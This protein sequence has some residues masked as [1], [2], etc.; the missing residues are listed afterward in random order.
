MT[1]D[2]SPASQSSIYNFSGIAAAPSQVC[3]HCLKVPRLHPADSTLN[4][5]GKHLCSFGSHAKR[6]R[7]DSNPC[8]QSPMDFESI[9]LTARTHCH[10]FTAN[11]SLPAHC[12]NDDICIIQLRIAGMMSHICTIPLR[13]ALKGSPKDTK[14][15][16][17]IYTRAS[18]PEH[19]KESTWH[20][21]FSND[22]KLTMSGSSCDLQCVA[23]KPVPSS[24]SACALR[25]QRQPQCLPPGLEHADRIAKS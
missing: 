10:M 16:A 8:G 6:Q 15:I 17:N 14:E 11:F 1:S 21:R 19:T 13:A 24:A 4:P 20:R 7:G 22:E 18:A 3:S 12:R 9:S 23:F 5:Q 25:R 2:S